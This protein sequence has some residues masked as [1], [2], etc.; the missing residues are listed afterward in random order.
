MRHEALAHDRDRPLAVP[1][2]LREA[3]ALGPLSRSGVELDPVPALELVPRG[4]RDAVVAQR[5]EEHGLPR[6]LAQLDSGDGAAACGLAEPRARV[7]DLA[8]FREVV[9]DG[10][11]HPLD[12]ADDANA[13][14]AAHRTS[15]VPLAR[16]QRLGSR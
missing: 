10:E 6:E 5:R 2:E 11:L 13:R 8:R 3:A 15:V 7:D 16:S 12:V 9:D 14:S 4:G 1:V